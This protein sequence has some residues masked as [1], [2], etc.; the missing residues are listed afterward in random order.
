MDLPDG[1]YYIGPQRV[2]TDEGS[3]QWNTQGSPTGNPDSRRIHTVLYMGSPL[4]NQHLAHVQ[5]LTR[6]EACHK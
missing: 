1:K 5:G 3:V 6:K 4:G 2:V